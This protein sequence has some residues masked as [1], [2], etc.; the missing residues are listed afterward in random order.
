MYFMSFCVRLVRI[1]KEVFNWE[2][3]LQLTDS[4]FGSFIKCEPEH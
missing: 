2:I 1:K 3:N 4:F